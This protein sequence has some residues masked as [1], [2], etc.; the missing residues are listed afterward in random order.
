[1]CACRDVVCVLVQP[2]YAFLAAHC[3]DEAGDVR[4]LYIDTV[5]GEYYENIKNYV[6][7]MHTHTSH[8][9]TDITQNDFEILFIIFSRARVYVCV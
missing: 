8:T 9:H 6:Y 2:A 7:V 3:T 5:G 4:Q 1:M